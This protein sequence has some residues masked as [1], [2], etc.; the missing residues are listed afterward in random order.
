MSRIGAIPIGS[1]G[2]RIENPDPAVQ[3]WLKKE[4]RTLIWA[5]QFG[6]EPA[7]F[8]L[9]K[10]REPWHTL[11]C[12][13]TRYRVEREYRTMRHLTSHN[14]P[15]PEP[16]GWARGHCQ[17]HGYFELLVMR[18]V[19]KAVDLQT[20]INNGYRPDVTALFTLARSMHEAGVCS[21]V[22]CSRNILVGNPGRTP[23]YTLIDFPRARIFPRS[24]VGTRVAKYDL[25]ML[26]EDLKGL[27]TAPS[28]SEITRYGMTR[29]E[30]RALW[31]A[32]ARRRGGKIARRLA[33]VECRM[34]HM[35]ASLSINN[36]EGVTSHDN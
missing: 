34:H 24:V 4:R 15:C 14:V 9:Y 32:A 21:Q 13:L 10:K 7:V 31:A 1:L 33:D 5:S 29:K 27:G 30:A 11:R 8:K 22:L 12:A 17:E 36:H 16:L 20:L 25:A 28:L 35:L 23:H 19:P 18:R 2:F 6:G 3:R 26:V